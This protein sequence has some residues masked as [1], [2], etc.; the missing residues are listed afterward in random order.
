MSRVLAMTQ[1][2][3]LGTFIERA[4]GDGGTEQ[5]HPLSHYRP[6]ADKISRSLAAIPEAPRRLWKPVDTPC[7]YGWTLILI[8]RKEPT[9]GLRK[10]TLLVCHLPRPGAGRCP[11]AVPGPSGQI[12]KWTGLEPPW[13]AS[14]ARSLHLV[15]TRSFLTFGPQYGYREGY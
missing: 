9:K 4:G 15:L 5:D 12:I 3:G 14:R 13:T 11:Q 7:R 10:N 6:L 8:G 1:I 2:G